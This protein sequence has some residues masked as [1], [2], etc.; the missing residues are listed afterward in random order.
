MAHAES[1]PL[2]QFLS[3]DGCPLADAARA[4]LERALEMCGLSAGQ[5]E[6]IDILDP[7]TP[8]GL[9]RWGSPTILVHGHDVSGHAQG[10]GVGCRL[11]D[12]KDQVPSAETIALAIRNCGI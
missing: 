2:I 9:A 6:A 7:Q 3:F 4:A 5:Y 1:A 10:D 8:E 12:T 11:Y